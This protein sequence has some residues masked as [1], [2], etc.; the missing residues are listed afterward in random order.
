MMRFWTEKVV[1]RVV[2]FRCAKL[3]EELEVEW[4]DECREFT[5]S[6]SLGILKIQINSSDFVYFF[7]LD[8]VLRFL[9]SRNNLLLSTCFVIRSSNRQTSGIN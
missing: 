2:G 9:R 5:E 4:C 7:F 3:C 1:G 8:R 6:L